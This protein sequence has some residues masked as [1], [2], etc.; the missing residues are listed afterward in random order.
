MNVSAIKHTYLCT[1]CY[2]SECVTHKIELFF[3]RCDIP[4]QELVSKICVLLNISNNMMGLAFYERS[5]AEKKKKSSS[6]LLSPADKA[7]SQR[8]Q[9]KNLFLPGHPLVYYFLN[10]SVETSRQTW[11]QNCQGTFCTT[12]SNVLCPVWLPGP[13]ETQS[14]SVPSALQVLGAHFINTCWE[15]RAR[16]TPRPGPCLSGQWMTDRAVFCST[17]WS[18]I[19]FARTLAMNTFLGCFTT[20]L[21]FPST[22]L[23]SE[24]LGALTFTFRGPVGLKPAATAPARTLG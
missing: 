11:L 9:R 10:S 22:V 2:I 23:C 16:G 24:H 21:T 3:H 18:L 20:Y 6:F 12:T 4:H 1:I 15:F 5:L 7:C 8:P 17:I 14:G 13:V 19:F